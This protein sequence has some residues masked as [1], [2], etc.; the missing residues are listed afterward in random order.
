MQSIWEIYDRILQVA[1][2]ANDNSK[3]TLKFPLFIRWSAHALVPLQTLLY[4]SVS[5]YLIS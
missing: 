4:Y 5:E 1:S 2:T 3:G